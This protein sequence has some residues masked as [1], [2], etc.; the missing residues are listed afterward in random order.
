MRHALLLAAATLAFGLAACSPQKA[1]GA[2]DAV[3]RMARREVEAIVKEYLVTHPEVIVEA[4]QTLNAREEQ[5]TFIKLI[6]E[7]DD[8]SIGNDN[9]PITIIEFFDYNCGYCKAANHWVFDKLD[10]SR[11]D[12]V[13]V[14]FKEYPVLA[15]SSHFAAQAAL[16]ANKQGKYREMH[17]ALMTGRDFSPEAIDKLAKSVG[18][19][20]NKFHADMRSQDVANHIARVLQEGADAQVQGTPGFFINGKSLSGFDEAQLDKLLKDARAAVKS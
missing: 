11:S 6:S 15:E 19:D 14:V 2:P 17:I 16:A 20:L 18:L 13:R 1:A 7:K 3:D 9:A 8:P 12:D 4:L 5:A 10:S